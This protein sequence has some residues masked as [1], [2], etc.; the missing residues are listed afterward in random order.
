MDSDEDRTILIYAGL[1]PLRKKWGLKSGRISSPWVSVLRPERWGTTLGF[2]AGGRS[3]DL[4]QGCRPGGC[5]GHRGRNHLKTP[6]DIQGTLDFVKSIPGITG[7]VLIIGDQLG[8]WGNIELMG[9]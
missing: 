9:M 7:C 6:E 5:C 1:S 8:A 3:G 4:G 2:P